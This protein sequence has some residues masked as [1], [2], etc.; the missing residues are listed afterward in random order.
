MS[1]FII[2]IYWNGRKFDGPQ[3]CTFEGDNRS[4]KIKKGFSFNAL[5]KKISTKLKLQSHQT[6]SSLTDFQLLEIV[7]HILLLR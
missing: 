2:F 5:K 7:V 1:T 6:I 3:E 4:S